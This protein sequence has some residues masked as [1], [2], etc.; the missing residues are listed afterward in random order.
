MNAPADSS[1]F[2]KTPVIAHF[3]ELRTRVLLSLVVFILASVVAYH[4][5]ADI[6]GVLVEPLARQF[7]EGDTRRLIYTHLTE[8]FFTYIKLAMFAGFIASFPFLA[9]QLYAFM[10]PGLYRKEKRVFWPYLVAA[11][12][13][14]VSG[15][16][17]AYFVIFPLA[18]QFFLSFEQFSPAGLPV[19]LEAKVSEYLSLSMQLIIAFGMAFQLPVV[20]ILLTHA[21]L[22]NPEVLVR[23]RRYAIVIIVAIAAII[24]PPDIIS[25][26]LLSIPVYTLYEISI[27]ICRRIA[28]KKTPDA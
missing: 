15:A 11:P 5:A 3:K 22:L 25:Q 16:A 21:G 14:F 6:Y 10:A 2:Q 18:W 24:T 26:V 19:Q 4:F 23:G 27:L 28:A 1:E 17:F 13:L 20:L 7:N 9:F 8:A 12:F